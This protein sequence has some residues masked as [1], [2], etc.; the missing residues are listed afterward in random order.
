MVC[1]KCTVGPEIILTHPM[2]LLG[3]V[4]QVDACF[5]PFEDSANL[6]ARYVHGLRR[7]YHMLRNRCWT[8]PMDPVVDV[9]LMECC[10]SPFGD[11]VSLSAR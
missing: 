1:A 2:V 8:H 7:T 4:A 11:S 9:G 3:D 10:F 6:N 5:G